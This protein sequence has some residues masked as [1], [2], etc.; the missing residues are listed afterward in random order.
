MDGSLHTGSSFLS[1]LPA[2]AARWF[3]TFA[4]T[5]SSLNYLSFVINGWLRGATVETRR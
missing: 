5:E 1:S 3:D 2:R 4:A